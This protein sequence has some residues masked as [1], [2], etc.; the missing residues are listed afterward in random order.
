[1]AFQDD[2]LQATGTIFAL[3]HQLKSMN[4][5]KSMHANNSFANTTKQAVVTHGF[6]IR[7]T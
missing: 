5:G 1:M 3:E 4:K 6:V 7:S 2:Q